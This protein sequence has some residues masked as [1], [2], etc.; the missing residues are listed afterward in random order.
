VD[1]RARVATAVLFALLAVRTGQDAS[2]RR[3]DPPAAVALAAYV[4]AL[5]DA[6]EV[7]VFGGPSARFFDL[8]AFPS[9]A[10]TVESMGDV[11]MTLTRLGRPPSRVFVTSEVSDLD[12]SPIPLTR[13]ATFCRPP[14][15]DRKHPCLDLYEGQVAGKISP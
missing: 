8:T 14:R 9:S 7:A 1:R 10:H 15:I 3:R 6:E 11:E 13:V 4:T 12:L 2:A 5:P